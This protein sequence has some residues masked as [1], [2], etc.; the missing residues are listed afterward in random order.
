MKITQNLNIAGYSFIVEQDAAIILE[1]YMN[2][3]SEACP[4]DGSKNEIL[5][6]IESRIAELLIEARGY[7]EV[8]WN[9]LRQKTAFRK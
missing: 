5:E 2:A 9:N 3:L 8:V 1:E 6:D 7:G 4:A